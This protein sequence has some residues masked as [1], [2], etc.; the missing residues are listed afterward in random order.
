[1]VRVGGITPLFGEPEALKPGSEGGTVMGVEFAIR[2]VNS[3][4]SGFRWIR[5][6]WPL[7]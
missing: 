7:A 3:S 5:V 2:V 4:E 6:S 1:M